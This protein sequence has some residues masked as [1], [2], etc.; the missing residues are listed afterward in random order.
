MLKPDV[1]RNYVSFQVPP[2]PKGDRINRPVH[3]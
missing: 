3:R 2:R 1:Q